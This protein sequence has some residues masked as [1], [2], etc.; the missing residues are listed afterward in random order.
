MWFYAV[1]M[2]TRILED[3]L[4]FSAVGLGIELYDWQLKLCAAVDRCSGLN[5][6][7]L[8]L[9]APNGAGKS[10][11]VIGVSI[12]RWLNRYPRG[13]VILTSADA[14]QIDSQIMPALKQHQGKFPGWE[15]L[16]RSIR[17]HDNGFFLAFTTDE[18]SRAEGH[19]SHKYSPLLII[20]DEAKSVE[21][22]IFQ[23]FDRCT[24]NVQLLVSSPGL[25]QGRFYDAF[26]AHRDQF[27]L[28]EQVGLKECP[29]IPKERIEDVLAIYGEDS[30]FT[31]STL[32][33]EF[34]AEEADQPMAVSYEKLVAL[35]SNPPGA[36]ISRSETSAFCDFAAGGDENV[37]AI[38][39]GNKLMDLICWRDKDTMASTGRFIME[40]RRAGLKPE[41]IWGDAGGL[42]HP[43]CDV[44]RDQGWPINRFDFGAKAYND[45]VYFNRA[46]EIWSNLAKSIDRGELVLINDPSLVSQLTTRKLHYDMKGRVRL[47]PK[48][49]LRA[50]GLKSPDRADAVAGA[51]AHGNLNY[52]HWARKVK[53]PWVQLDHWWEDYE[54]IRANEPE[55]EFAE[56]QKDMGCWTG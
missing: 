19:H 42:G 31:R 45:K 46:V 37:L 39:S 18:E 32:Y 24:F 26:T 6:V 35:L 41:Q 52:N 11:R 20:I 50:R 56:L 38:R 36:R 48:E 54:K 5:R 7:K 15:F 34:M 25:K 17:T 53:D 33:G 49:D 9:S 16:G 22:G 14:K 44:L 8:A 29:H 1:L 12:L 51:F 28:T 13:R 43:I 27:L 4:A 30:P 10:E 23:A 55:S 2:A 21:Q 47:E 3:V 40:F